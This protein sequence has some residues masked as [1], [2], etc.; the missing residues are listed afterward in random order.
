MPEAAQFEE[1]YGED[2]GG[3]D[4]TPTLGADVVVAVTAEETPSWAWA[5]AKVIQNGEITYTAS[6]SGLP[7]VESSQSRI[8]I[9][10]GSVGCRIFVRYD[11]ISM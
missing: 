7:I 11:P 3:V 10:R 8:A 5:L 6:M 9:T 4:E 2:E 1:E